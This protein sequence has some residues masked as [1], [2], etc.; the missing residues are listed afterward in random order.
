MPLHSRPR[1]PSLVALVATL[2]GALLVASLAPTA[3]AASLLAIDYGTDS[4]KASVVK[5]GIPF[6]V[7]LTKE[8][9]RKAP[10]IVTFRG[11]ERLVAGDA[12][13]LVRRASLFTRV[14]AAH[15]QTS[16]RRPLAFRKTLSPPSSSSSRTPPRTPSRSSTRPSSR[17]LRQRLPAALPHFRPRS[18]PFRS[19]KRSRTSLC[20]PRRWPRNKPRN[21]SERRS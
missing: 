6:D 12:Q 20:T 13:S 18:S 8:G 7:L 14:G 19:K 15:P 2:V 21:P 9:K 3:R 10:S 5:P 1:H 17:F 16:K 4:F 11:D